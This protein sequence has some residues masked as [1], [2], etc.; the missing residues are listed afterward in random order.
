MDFDGEPSRFLEYDVDTSRP[1][2]MHSVS[3]PSWHSVWSHMLDYFGV[4]TYLLTDSDD[5]SFSVA[6]SSESKMQPSC[7]TTE[8]PLQQEKHGVKLVGCDTWSNLSH[9]RSAKTNRCDC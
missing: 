3:S 6:R 9:T 8:W 1:T 7:S 5:V 2:G 4:D